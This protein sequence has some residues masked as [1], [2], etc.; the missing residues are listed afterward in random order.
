[1]AVLLETFPEEEEALVAVVV[2]AVSGAAVS[3]VAGPVEAGRKRMVCRH[4]NEYCSN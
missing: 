4:N 2:L 3:V 1:M